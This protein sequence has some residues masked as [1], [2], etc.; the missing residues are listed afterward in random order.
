[1][2]EA[3]LAKTRAAYAETR[4]RP[5]LVMNPLPKVYEDFIQ[6]ALDEL[7][8]KRQANASRQ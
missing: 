8:K 1:M 4:E 5:K 6:Q 7:A 2:P 3:R